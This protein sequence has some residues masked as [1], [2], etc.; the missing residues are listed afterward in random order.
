MF[1]CLS[2]A[3]SRET[4]KPLRGCRVALVVVVVV[5]VAWVDFLTDGPQCALQIDQGARAAAD[6]WRVLV[7]HLME[8]ANML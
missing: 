2:S 3:S 1:F 8:D 6:R 4:A 7:T 5:V